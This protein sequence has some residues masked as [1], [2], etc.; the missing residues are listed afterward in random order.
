MLIF[1]ICNFNQKEKKRKKS[2]ITFQTVSGTTLFH[3][4]RPLLC[5]NGH[6]IESCIL[7]NPFELCLCFL[8][9]YLVLIIFTRRR[10]RRIQKWLSSVR[11]PVPK[12]VSTTSSRPS[13]PTFLKL[14][15]FF[16]WLR[17]EVV[18]VHMQ[19]VKVT[20]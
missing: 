11:T 15:S 18:H 19:S 16:F 12:I 10:R 2:I 1:C 13:H 14:G 6:S 4:N 5:V 7:P 8:F 3:E 9:I 20:D 17:Y